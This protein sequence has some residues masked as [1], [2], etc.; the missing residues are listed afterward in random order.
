MD[1]DADIPGDRIAPSG[2]LELDHMQDSGE[3]GQEFFV[4][5]AKCPVDLHIGKSCGDPTRVASM[6]VAG[7]SDPLPARCFQIV[8]E[9]LKDPVFHQLP[10]GGWD[11]L[12]IEQSRTAHAPKMRRSG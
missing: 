7:R 1:S 11:A 8:Q 2:A 12:R 3:S 5:L 6:G 10:F 9:T 4:A